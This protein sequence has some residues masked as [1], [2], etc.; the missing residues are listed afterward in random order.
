MPYL[1]GEDKKLI[2]REQNNIMNME[3]III[4]VIIVYLYSERKTYDIDA[5][6]V[7]IGCS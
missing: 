2:F 3:V 7:K 5:G 4:F 1:V 6:P